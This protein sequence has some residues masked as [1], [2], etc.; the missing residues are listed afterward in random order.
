M[1]QIVKIILLFAVFIIIFLIYPGPLLAQFSADD[2]VEPAFCKQCHN[3][4]YAQWSKSMHS[5][6][7]S[8]PIFRSALKLAVKDMGGENSASGQMIQRYCLNCHAPI[9]NLTGDIPPRSSLAR[10]GI[11]CDFCHTI[12]GS[13][14]IGNASYLVSPGYIKRGPFGDA[15]SPIHETAYSEFHT[16]SEFCGMCHEVFHPIYGT[17]LETTY[18]EWR[19]GPYSTKGIQC[20]SC[21][22]GSEKNAR[23]AVQG[24]IR[25]LIRTHEFAGGN[26]VLGDRESALKLLRG[27]AK[28]D[29]KVSKKKAKPGE[30]IEIKVGVTNVG[31]G[32]KIPTG[33]TDLR[34]MWLEIKVIDSENRQQIL[35]K[36]RYHTVF[37]DEKGV[38]GEEV[39]KWRAARIYS[40]NRIAPKERRAYR[41]Y[42]SIPKD[43]SGDFRIVAALKYRSL[44]PKIS[45]KLGLRPLPAVD[46]ALAET[47]ISLPGTV[48]LSRVL[49]PFSLVSILILVGAILFMLLAWRWRGRFS[50]R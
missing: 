17:P 36:E 24:P 8:D 13:T 2:F 11:S 15:D 20:Q 50:R 4:I 6:A 32:H 12:S 35:F 1:N 9:G 43:A 30:E 28:I 26:F 18:T 22:M 29:L 33:V 39:P 49:N 45:Q 19:E 40:D 14:G 46:M 16:K 23:A 27:A 21:M 47:M 25:S 48:K 44:S 5:K 37:E 41:K 10:S 38:H 7:Y 34:D 3:E 31:A 42:F